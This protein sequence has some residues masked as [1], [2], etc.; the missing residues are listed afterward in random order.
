[1]KSGLNGS[2]RGIGQ[3]DP[4]YDIVNMSQKLLLTS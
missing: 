2:T 1:M 3:A 4:E